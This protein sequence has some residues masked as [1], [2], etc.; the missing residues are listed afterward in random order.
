MQLL[1]SMIILWGISPGPVTVAT[2]LNARK[3]GRMAGVAV[4]SG[5]TLIAALV[6]VAALFIEGL[7]FR[8][9][10]ES[11]R[12]S[13]FEQLGASGI[14]LMGL[15]AGYRTLWPTVR[16]HQT[17]NQYTNTNRGFLQGVMISATYIPQALVFFTIIVPQTV[18]VESATTAILF[19]GGLRVCLNLF[20]HSLIAIIATRADRWMS[21]NR[22]EKWLE[23]SAA[24]LMVG[25]GTN[26]LVG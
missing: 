9:A 17:T 14:V 4:A 2:L 23:L 1:T 13:I 10:I 11:S 24:T 25:I 3:H 22:F 12:L 19:L 26:A 6:T 7:G 21:N 20:Y 15:L 16:T 8:E 5:A 18:K